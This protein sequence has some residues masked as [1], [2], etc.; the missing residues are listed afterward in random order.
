MHEPAE[1][2]T[3]SSC[4]AV[5]LIDDNIYLQAAMREHLEAAGY[6]VASAS[7]GEEA[8]ALLPDLPAPCL[9]LLDLMMPGMNGWDFLNRLRREPRLSRTTVAVVSAARTPR[10]EGVARFLH[11]PFSPRD[12]L[13]LV[14]EFCGPPQACEPQ[15]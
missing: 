13:A 6:A 11:K 8:L 14:E 4:R 7:G 3:P 2:K 15:R 5:L 1:Q 10:P 12:L 9:V